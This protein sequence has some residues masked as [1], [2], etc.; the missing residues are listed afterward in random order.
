M[1][2]STIK[3]FGHMITNPSTWSNDSIVAAVGLFKAKL[4]S[5]FKI[6]LHSVKH[7]VSYTES[8]TRSLQANALRL[9]QAVQHIGTLKWVLR[10]A[11]SNINSHFHATFE[12]EPVCIGA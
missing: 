10:D 12:S 1:F 5:E 8:L 2:D 6:T 9:L 7:Y 3:S 4:K 11:R